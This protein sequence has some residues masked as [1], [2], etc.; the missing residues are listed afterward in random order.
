MVHLLR[1][2]VNR[3]G[4]SGAALPRLCTVLLVLAL[5]ASIAAWA[6]EFTSRRSPS[7]PLRAIPT[8]NPVARTLA[9]DTAPIAQMFGARAGGEGAD[10]RLVGVIALGGQGRGIA[11]L[12]VDGRPALATRAGE[13]I[14]GGVTLTEVHTDG[15]L[16][17]RSGATQE[18]LLPKKAAPV[19]IT[20]VP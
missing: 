9:A 15:V 4:I 13:E 18:L 20:R 10:I 6:L 7:E 16:L 19:G 12:A 17:N 8:G 2:I 5:A 1:N 14:A 11:L 3:L